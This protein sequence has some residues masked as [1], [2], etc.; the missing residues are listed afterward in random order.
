MARSTLCSRCKIEKEPGRETQSYCKACKT[1]YLKERRKNIVKAEPEPRRPRRNAE[2]AKRCPDCNKRKENLKQ[3]YCNSCRSVRSKAWNLATGRVKKHRDGLCPCGAE[4][5]EN[6]KYYCLAC[7]A[8]KSR[9]W[10]ESKRPSKTE[11][12]AAAAE[13]RLIASFKR[14]VRKITEEYIRKGVLV[15]QPCEKC[16]TEEK[17][18]A[19]HDDYNKPLNV[20]WLCRKHHLEHHRKHKD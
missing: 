10:R 3:T 6:Q 4:R 2:A 9:R 18:E 15:K 7:K 1:E 11:A 8:E 12:D 5:G 13:K 19:H 20:R 17:I 16:G 14:N